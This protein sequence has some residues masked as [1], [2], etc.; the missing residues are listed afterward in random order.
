LVDVLKIATGNLLEANTESVVNTVNCV[1]VMGKGIALQFKQVYPENFDAYKRAC[2]AGEIRPGRMFT[3]ATGSLIGP[4]YIVNFPTKR[5]WKGKSRIEDIQDSLQALI[6]EVRRL[7]I[8]S[9]AVPPLGCGNGGL[10]WAVVRPLIE[11]SFRSIPEVE[12]LLYAPSGAPEAESMPVRTERPKMTRARALFIKLIE[13]YSE[14]Q[15]RLSLLEIQKLAFFLQEAGEGMKL[16]FEK[17]KYGPYAD[18]LNHVLQR[19]EGHFIRGYGDRSQDA[20]IRLMPGAIEKA[21][22]LLREHSDARERLGR[23]SRLIEGF[24]TPYG[25][26]LLAT[27]YWVAKK[28]DAPAREPDEA[29]EQV[30]DWN[31]RKRKMFQPNHIRVA[32]ERLREEHWLN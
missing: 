6:E 7:G 31:E 8:R 9:I 21:D 28:E 23:V 25:M 24:E 1:G 29:I 12:V 18:N 13:Q 30:H 3:F 16:N 20:S 4:R 14:F 15:Y 10:D 17:G 32:W 5:H 11:E 2:D 26:E 27:V 22:E 19:L